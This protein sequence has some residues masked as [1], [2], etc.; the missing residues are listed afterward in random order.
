M[1]QQFGRPGGI[2]TIFRILPYL[3]YS[4][5]IAIGLLIISI[6]LWAF[7]AK[8]KLRWVKVL[9]IILTILVVITG[10]LGTVSI[11]S[12]R[13]MEQR[14]FQERGMPDGFER[15]GQRMKDGENINKSN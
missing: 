2:F 10:A 1:E 14:G 3:R 12:G 8:K 9:A 6:V 11:L 15:D 5:Y 4:L 13:N 7:F